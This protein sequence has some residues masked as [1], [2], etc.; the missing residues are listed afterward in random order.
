MPTI[1]DEIEPG[2]RSFA[3]AQSLNDPQKGLSANVFSIFTRATLAEREIR[4]SDLNTFRRE[5]H[6]PMRSP[7]ATAAA[8]SAS[9]NEVGL[10]TMTAGI[11]RAG[12]S[13]RQ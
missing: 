7:A 5:K 6:Q 1:K 2:L 8:N 9:G 4:R 3:I 10:V 13:K 12:K 11:L